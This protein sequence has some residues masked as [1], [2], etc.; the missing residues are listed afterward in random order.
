MRH[1]IA[2]AAVGCLDHVLHLAR[3]GR[4]HH[5]ILGRDQ[6]GHPLVPQHL[7]QPFTLV[8]GIQIE[9]VQNEY[10]GLAHLGQGRQRRVFGLIEI[11]IGDKQD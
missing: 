2:L 4:S 3:I 6:V 9:L 1:S 7:Q 8:S 10:D 11:R 5:D